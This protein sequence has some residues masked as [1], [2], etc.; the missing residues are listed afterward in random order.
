[1]CYVCHEDQTIKQFLPH[2]GTQILWSWNEKTGTIKWT[3]LAIYYT[4]YSVSV[5]RMTQKH[6][7]EGQ[8][9]SVPLIQP[10]LRREEAVHQIAD[11]LLYLETISTDI[12]RRQV[13]KL[14]HSTLFAIIKGS[15]RFALENWQFFSLSNKW[16]VCFKWN[17][18]WYQYLI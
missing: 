8:V 11:A 1:M 16:F 10:D 18:S 17:M 9:Y 12:F 6:Y 4:R 13:Q 2:A 5:V 14:F 3:M 15:W 7:L